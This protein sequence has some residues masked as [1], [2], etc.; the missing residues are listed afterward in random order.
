[1]RKIDPNDPTVCQ[2][3][4]QSEE[5]AEKPWRARVVELEKE[6]EKLHEKIARLAKACVELS[7]RNLAAME[8]K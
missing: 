1:M 7:G 8:R 4:G 3:C 2:V 5:N 6:N